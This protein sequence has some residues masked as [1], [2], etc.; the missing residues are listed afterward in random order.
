M[1]K[2]FIF[3][4]SLAVLLLSGCDTNNLKIDSSDNL[5]FL[6]NSNTQPENL[7]SQITNENI[8]NNSGD[9][10]N[11]EEKPSTLFSNEHLEIS[12]LPNWKAKELASGAINIT[13][14]NYILYINPFTSQA[15][16][17]E[18]G[19]FSEIA[20]GAPGVELV[21]KSH[22][23]NPC[24]THENTETTNKYN[25]QIVRTEYFVSSDSIKGD[26]NCNTP[27]N[28]KNVWYFS[29]ITTK[30]DGYFAKGEKFNPP[31]VNPD[32]QFVVTMSYNAKNINELPE[33]SSKELKK[34]I[35]QMTEMVQGMK[36][37]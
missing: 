25:R 8:T 37:K 20:Q 24:G 22:P 29:Y 14:G 11:V 27:D 9:D 19:R 17:V 36:L 21:L 7:N 5:N 18:G 16:G 12:V 34:M 35:Q 15:S 2:K 23:A 28:L 26:E 31:I 6:K 33:Q 10:Q 1:S 3:L 32:W 13:S 30:G 4:F